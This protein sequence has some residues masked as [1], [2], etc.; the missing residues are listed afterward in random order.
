M[1]ALGRATRGQRTLFERGQLFRRVRN[2]AG[3]Q[4]F[5]AGAQNSDARILIASTAALV[6]F[7]AVPGRA[8]L[9]FIS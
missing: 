4:S 6:T 1:L 7:A 2:L 9:Y 8:A 5:E 3:F